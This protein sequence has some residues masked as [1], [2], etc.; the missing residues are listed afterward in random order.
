[1]PSHEA[2]LEPQVEEEEMQNLKARE[3]GWTQ[4]LEQRERIL[5]DVHSRLFPHNTLH[6]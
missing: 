1:M 4:L 3:W 5:V 2:L 6:L